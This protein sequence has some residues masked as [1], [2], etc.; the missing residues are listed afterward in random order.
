MPTQKKR[1]QLSPTGITPVQAEKRRLDAL[2]CNKI[3]C[4]YQL[5]AL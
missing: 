2:V 1:I 5:L 3:T 4:Y